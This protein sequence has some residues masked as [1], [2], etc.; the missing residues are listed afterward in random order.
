MDDAEAVLARAA[1]AVLVSI[2][3]IT[4]RPVEMDTVRRRVRKAAGKAIRKQVSKRPVL[5]PVVIEV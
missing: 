2:E 5:F 4:E 1:E 3:Q